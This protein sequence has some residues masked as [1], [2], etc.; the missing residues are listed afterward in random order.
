MFD[1][2]MV[3]NLAWLLPIAFIL[4]LLLEQV[5]SSTIKIVLPSVCEILLFLFVVVLNP[6]DETGFLIVAAQIC[7]PLIL[8]FFLLVPLPIIEKKAGSSLGKIPVLTGM[9]ITLVVFFLLS[10]NRFH[11]IR[12]QSA[13][14]LPWLVGLSVI[15]SIV[16]FGIAHLLSSRK[17]S[18]EKLPVT[19]EATKNNSRDILRKMVKIAALLTILILLCSPFVIIGYL[20]GFSTAAGFNIYSVNG[21]PAQNSTVIHL[22]DDNFREFPRMT[23]IIRDDNPEKRD[24]VKFYDVQGSCLIGNGSYSLNEGPQFYKYENR[25]FEGSI[26]HS[27]DIYLEYNGEFYFMRKT[28]RT[29]F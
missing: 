22:T 20:Q 3:F 2:S 5:Q 28:W 25:N 23:S 14:T 18:T 1:L 7:G 19:P 4:Y 15:S 13:D 24:C 10:Q 12:P 17:Q 29:G 11:D 6:Q 21:I 8:P 26:D 27:R 9:L 16:F